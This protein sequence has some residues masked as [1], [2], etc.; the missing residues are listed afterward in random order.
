MGDHLRRH[1][2]R[3]SAGSGTCA[4]RTQCVLTRSGGL[5]G[6]DVRRRLRGVFW[7]VCSLAGMAIAPARANEAPRMAPT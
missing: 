4:D 2:N 7:T 1:R 5:I 3:A 6:K